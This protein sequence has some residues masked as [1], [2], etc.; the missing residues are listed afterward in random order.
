MRK[1]GKWILSVVAKALVIILVILLLPFARSLFRMIMPDVT[2]EIEVQRRVLEQKLESSK[3]LEVTT[4]DEEGILDAKTNVIIFGTVGSTV[5]R[6]RYTASVGFDLSKVTITGDSNRMI[7]S[8]PEAEILNDGIEALEINRHN[9]FSKAI[10]KSVETLLYEQR[11]KCRE[12]YLSGEQHS[13]RSWQDLVAAFEETIC[14]WLEGYGERHYQ[15]E[16][17]RQEET[18]AGAAAAF[19]ILPEGT[20]RRRLCSP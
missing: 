12:E 18:A 14:Q 11:L 9:F 5:I 13:G 3:R 2:G 1:H 16:F 8:L 19:L 7:F 6:Y 20:C 15:F 4:V 17:V 10:E